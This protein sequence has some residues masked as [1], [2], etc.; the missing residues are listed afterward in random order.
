MFLI[1][2]GILLENINNDFGI[3]LGEFQYNIFKEIL[4]HKKNTYLFKM[5]L[6]KYNLTDLLKRGKGIIQNY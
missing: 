1:G 4:F 6:D 3:I 2:Q 5:C